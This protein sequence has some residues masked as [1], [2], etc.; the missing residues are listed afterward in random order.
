MRRWTLVLGF[1][2]VSALIS[3]LTWTS[4]FAQAVVFAPGNYRIS[5]VVD[6]RK[7]NGDRWDTIGPFS[8]PEPIVCIILPNTE[9]CLGSPASPECRDTFVCEYALPVFI[10]QQR[11][12]FR[13]FD[14]D[15]L[16]NDAIGQGFCLI[17]AIDCDIGA[18]K[19]TAVMI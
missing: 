2:V 5:I 6:P 17:P 16:L 3:P 8:P 12:E 11:I 1:G 4:A 19:I 10:E 9:I 7:L 13:A 18:G 15:G 14:E